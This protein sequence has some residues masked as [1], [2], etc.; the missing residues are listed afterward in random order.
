MKLYGIIEDCAV[1]ICTPK[2][3][4]HTLSLSNGDDQPSKTQGSGLLANIFSDLIHLIAKEVPAVC[5]Q[6]KHLFPQ[7]LSLLL[8]LH[9]HNHRHNRYTLGHSVMVQGK[10]PNSLRERTASLERSTSKKKLPHDPLKKKDFKVN[11]STQN[12]VRFSASNHN[13]IWYFWRWNR[14]FYWFNH[15]VLSWLLMGH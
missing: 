14:E 15:N 13:R 4:K 12:H 10:P 2:S 8:H 3:N 7:N 5:K 9:L 6:Q 1:D 11:T